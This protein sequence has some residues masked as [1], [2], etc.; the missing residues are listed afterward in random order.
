M[1]L[2]AFFKAKTGPL[3]NWVW[4]GVAVVGLGVG[5]FVMKRQQ[6]QASQDA[7]ATQ[8]PN[9]TADQTTAG[10]DPSAQNGHEVI[11]VPIGDY[12]TQNNVPDNTTRQ[13]PSSGG[14]RPIPP[15]TFIT[16]RNRYSI[17]IPSVQ[18]YDKLSPG[19]IP[20]RPTPGSSSETRKAPFGSQ[21]ETTGPAISGPSNTS[22]TNLGSTSWYPVTGGYIS[23][24]D[25][26]GTTKQA[27]SVPSN[28]TVQ[29][30][31]STGSTNNVNS[32][33]TRNVNT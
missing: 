27:N 28:G 2:G 4:V 29:Q 17:N 13:R 8:D 18:N 14:S 20:V 30:N 1:N 10:Y 16:I 33:T 9:A 21:Q 5:I 26:V 24:L 23:G 3:P 19:G 15:K 31:T 22:E 6:A 11:I 32:S 7:T 25:V 12:Q